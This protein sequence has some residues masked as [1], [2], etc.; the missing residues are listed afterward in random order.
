VIEPLCINESVVRPTD[1]VDNEP[2]K[3][4]KLGDS[5]TRYTQED[6]VRRKREWQGGEMAPNVTF[7]MTL[8][9][10]HCGGEDRSGNPLNL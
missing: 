9:R 2:V 3:N 10:A 7:C 6:P 8:S 1:E 5:W 4:C